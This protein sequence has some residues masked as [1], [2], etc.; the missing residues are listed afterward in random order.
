MKKKFLIFKNERE[1]KLLL[2][3]NDHQFGKK[4]VSSEYCKKWF[5]ISDF[6]NFNFKIEKFIFDNSNSTV[7]WLDVYG[8]ESEKKDMFRLNLFAQDRRCARKLAITERHR[9]CILTASL[10]IIYMAVMLTSI[11]ETVFTSMPTMS[12]L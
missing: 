4:I 2:I 9:C 11:Y 12:G 3:I 8:F 5:Q 7:T 10:F 6:K 1:R